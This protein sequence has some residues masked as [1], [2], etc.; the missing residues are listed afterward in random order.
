MSKFVEQVQVFF[1]QLRE[2]TLHFTENLS[3]IVSGYIMHKLATQELD[4]VP[5]ELQHCLEDRD[6]IMNLLAGMKD[7]HIQRI[8]EREDRLMT[9]SKEFIENMVDKLN[10]YVNQIIF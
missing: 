1:A 10:Q 7:V 3:E 5:E 8:D 2:V 4:D 9:R 6:A